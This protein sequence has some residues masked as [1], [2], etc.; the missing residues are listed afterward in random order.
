MVGDTTDGCPNLTGNNVGPLKRIQD[1]VTEINLEI[2]L[3]IS[4]C[5]IHLNVLCKSVLKLNHVIDVV[6]KRVNFITAQSSNHRQFV[7]FMEELEHGD[8]GDHA[9]VR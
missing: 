5:I 9:T 8:I 4:H 3:V 1:K 6:N 2:K 7:A